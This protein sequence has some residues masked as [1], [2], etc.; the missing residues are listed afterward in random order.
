M[1]SVWDEV[2]ATG[3]SSGP[4]GTVG[5]WPCSV[6]AQSSA[7]E[8]WGCGRPVRGTC[9]AR[10]AP[11]LRVGGQQLPGWDGCEVSEGRHNWGTPPPPGYAPAWPGQGRQH[12]FRFEESLCLLVSGRT[13][14]TGSGEAEFQLGI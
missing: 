6:G 14:S 7:L 10:P 2:T 1:C 3:R 11:V 8:D 9:R 4:Q 5:V 13:L 12:G